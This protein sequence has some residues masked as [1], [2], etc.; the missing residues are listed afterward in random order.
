MGGGGTWRKT[1]REV[2]KTKHGF[3]GIAYTG[4]EATTMAIL[5]SFGN[6]AIDGVP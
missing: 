2:V 4:W 5:D 6:G 1:T 3:V